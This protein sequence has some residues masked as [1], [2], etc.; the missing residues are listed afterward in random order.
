M[1]SLGA[2][3]AIANTYS[4][5]EMES[6]DEE[7]S[8]ETFLDDSEYVKESILISVVREAVRRVEYAKS[9]SYRT[10]KTDDQQ[11]T[12]SSEVSSNEESTS[13]EDT[14]SSDSE[15]VIFVG[16]KEANKDSLKKRKPPPM[17]HGE[18]LSSDLPP[19]EDLHITV[20]E[21]EC[22]EIGTIQSHIEEMI[23]V[24]S[25]QNSAALDLESVLF[26]DKGQRPLGKVFD[27][28][29]PVM[30]PFYCV[31]FNSKEHVLE[32]KIEVGMPVFFAPRTEHT[33]FVFLAELM[34]MKGSDASWEN[35]REPPAFACDYSDD[36]EERMARK[37]QKRKNF[38]RDDPNAGDKKS[39]SASPQL[40]NNAYVPPSPRVQY[41]NAFYRQERSYNPRNYGPIR[42]N[43]GN[44]NINLK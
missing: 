33:N 9:I 24:K 38:V 17:V 37:A 31:R 4:D 35:D 15:G 21:Y 19:I 11:I 5:S 42:W 14:D 7:D 32:K 8:M 13:S 25:K 3:A 41:N 29:G 43:S 1:A 2:L 44:R 34:K 16:N 18:L 28:I 36:E 6:S 10:K 27:V 20:P 40:S 26:L 23:V 22:I 12:D 39:A 30:Q